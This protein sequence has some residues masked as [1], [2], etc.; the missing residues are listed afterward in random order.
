MPR[1]ARTCTCTRAKISA[2][3]GALALAVLLG[4]SSAAGAQPLRPIGDERLDALAQRYFAQTWQL[5]PVRAT[6]AGVHDMDDRLGS[7]TPDAYAARLALARTTL[8][9]LRAIEPGTMGAEAADDAQILESRLQATILDLSGLETW[10]HK[11]SSYAQIASQAVYGLISRDFAP[12]PDRV[13]AVVAR[14]RQIPAMLDGAAGNIT[15]VDAT[16]ADLARA[17]IAG[18]IAFFES[19]VPAAVAPV[20]D[21]VLRAE[22]AT[23]NAATV[24]ALKRYAAALDAGPFA[25][26]SGTFAIGP[27]TFAEKLRLQ[28]LSPISLATYESVGEAALAQTKADFI[29]TAKKVD[30]TKSPAEVAASLGASHPAADALLAKAASDLATLR[31]FV[32]AHHIITLPPDD[33]VT[34]AATPE[35]A[36]QTTFASMNAPGPLETKATRAYYY[37][38]PVEPE[39]SAERKEQHLA[40]F[41][42]FSFP[43]V[44]A[45]EV[46]P[47]HYVNFALDRHEKLSL[48]RKLLPS[49]SFAEGWAHYDEQMMVDQGWGN[50]DPRVRLAQLQLALQRECRYLVGLREHTQNMSVAAATAFFEQNAFMAPEP[51]HREALRGTQ[52]PL[53]GYYTLGKLEILKLRGDAAKLAGSRF[54][55]ETFHDQLLAHGDPPIAIVRKIVLGADDD[56]KLL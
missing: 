25:H 3:R 47:G 23:A 33:D 26:P 35:F 29:E 6:Q 52:D 24:A 20:R 50:G 44:S 36:R 42:D 38:T 4:L 27:A 12:L 37:V 2:A 8:E 56:G 55:L 10:K 40:F 45:H 18:S 15:T 5:D 14:E 22:F 19:V 34:V 7:Y 51:S 31:T 48:I 46:M 17:D 54:D 28:E 1:T 30:A 43:I 16:T 9:Q 41:N 32:I 13:R 21:G 49:A 39:W 11:P 53:Y